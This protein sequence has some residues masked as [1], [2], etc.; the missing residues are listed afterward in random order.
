MVHFY[1]LHLCLQDIYMTWHDLP[2]SNLIIHLSY[3]II[4][5][6]YKTMVIVEYIWLRIQPYKVY[7]VKIK[8]NN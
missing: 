3:I 6:C 4:I 8:I 1:S 2:N 5:F 7:I